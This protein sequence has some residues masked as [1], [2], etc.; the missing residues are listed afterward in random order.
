MY[1]LF[2]FN[3]FYLFV[4]LILWIVTKPVWVILYNSVYLPTGLW[5]FFLTHLY[6]L[7]GINASQCYHKVLGVQCISRSKYHEFCSQLLATRHV[8]YL[9]EI[10]LAQTAVFLA[11]C[12]RIGLPSQSPLNG[13]T[14]NFHLIPFLDSECLISDYFSQS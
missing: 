13:D 10:F 8:L 3:C 14:R 6:F 9:L 4:Y 2:I 5:S 12:L 1:C 11:L 7:F